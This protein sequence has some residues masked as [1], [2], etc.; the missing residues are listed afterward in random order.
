MSIF[1]ETLPMQGSPPNF[2]QNE[3][4]ISNL[5]D[6]PKIGISEKIRE[7]IEHFYK[8]LMVSLNLT[9]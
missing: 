2:G 4:V 8:N 5:W 1:A 7:Y 3:G 9:L 6:V